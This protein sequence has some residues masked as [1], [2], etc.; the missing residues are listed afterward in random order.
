MFLLFSG[1]GK[2]K[3][4]NTEFPTQKTH[5]WSSVKH[6]LPL[7]FQEKTTSHTAFPGLSPTHFKM[8]QL[9]LWPELA[10]AM[11]LGS[12]KSFPLNANARKSMPKLENKEKR[13]YMKGI[14]CENT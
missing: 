12:S 4:I 9:C 10:T 1:T 7:T 11:L 6:G 3:K 8:L 5:K 14:P 2:K 13:N